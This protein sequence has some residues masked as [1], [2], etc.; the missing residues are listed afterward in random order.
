MKMYII[1][2]ESCT[3]QLS[4][5]IQY[6][7]RNWTVQLLYHRKLDS[8]LNAPEIVSRP[9][10]LHVM[11]LPWTAL[12]FILTGYD[13][14]PSYIISH[15]LVIRWRYHMYNTDSFLGLLY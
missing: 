5:D 7:L 12:D 8:L 13:Y 1:L 3:S 15:G 9:S 2:L 11:F 4:S 6:M 10:M 14:G